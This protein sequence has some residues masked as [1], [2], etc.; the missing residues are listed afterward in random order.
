MLQ[1]CHPK[2]SKIKR[3]QWD[4][5]ILDMSTA[6]LAGVSSQGLEHQAGKLIEKSELGRHR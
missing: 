2:S 6:C 5:R 3:C 4:L 1:S